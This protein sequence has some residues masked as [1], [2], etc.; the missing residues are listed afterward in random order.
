MNEG[1]RLEKPLTYAELSKLY[2]AEKQKHDLLRNS[3]KTRENRFLDVMGLFPLVVVNEHQKIQAINRFARAIFEYEDSSEVQDKPVDF[4]FPGL[5][6]I[7]LRTDPVQV[8][9]QRKSGERFAAELIVNTFDDRNL[10][11]TVNDITERHRLEQLRKD[12]IAM[13]SHDMRSPLTAVKVVL[14]M[15]ADGVGGELNPRGTRIINNAQASVLYLISLVSNLLDNEKIESG[16]IEI[17]VTEASV[18]S[19]VSKAIMTVDAAKQRPTVTL[20]SETTN[21]RFLGDEDRIVQVLINLISNAIKYSPDDSVVKVV[22]GI[23][24]LAIK[25]Q[26]IDK[27]PGIPQEL[28]HQ[29]FERYKQLEQHKEIKRQGF[30][31]GLAICKALVEKQHG[32]IWVESEV[33]KGSKFCFTVPLAPP[34]D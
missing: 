13:V 11:V 21:D 1:E 23:E 9:G 4:L 18:D 30:G 28:Q 25:F 20:E 26:V 8:V 32:R 12:L 34:E 6:K 14:D 29:I 16:T 19:V 7:S 5:E 24:G 2:K 17:H 27:G 31:L 3:T 15:V 10:L 22:A 33:G